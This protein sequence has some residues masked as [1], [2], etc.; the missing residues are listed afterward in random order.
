MRK[1]SLSYL[2][3][4]TRGN[5]TG[6]R[7]SSTF[8]LVSMK[9]DLWI[10]ASK[11]QIRLDLRSQCSHPPTHTYCIPSANQLIKHDNGK[12]KTSRFT[13]HF[14]WSCFKL[15]KE[16][17]DLKGRCIVN[18]NDWRPFDPSLAQLRAVLRSPRR[19]SAMMTT[20]RRFAFIFPMASGGL[21][22]R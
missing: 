7:M 19:P 16:P 1:S 12:S 9:C 6:L 11:L 21:G 17:K 22:T 5:A 8:I 14:P 2:P 10:H 13:G 4:S 20:P 3:T 18:R 15:P